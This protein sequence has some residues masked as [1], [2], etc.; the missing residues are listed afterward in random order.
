MSATDPQQKL[1]FN[2]IDA[3]SGEYMFEPLSAAELAASITGAAPP[4]LDLESTKQHL[5]DLEFRHRQGSEAHF[6]VKAGIDATR[7]EE[8]GWAVIFPAASEGS[9]AAREQAAI[10]EALAPLLGLRKSQATAG[11][12]DYYKEYLGEL[13]YR[14][15]ETKQQFL[16]RLGTGPGPADPEK[17]PYYLLIVGSP[18]QIPYH[19][20]YQLD[21]QYAVGRIYFDTIDEY[22]NYA[23]SVV[24]AESGPSLRAR[25]LAFVGVANPD[26]T[27]TTLSRKHLIAP[28]VERVTGSELGKDWTIDCYLDERADKAN[29]AR[30]FGGPQTP[31]LIFSASHGMAFKKGDPLQERHQGALL[32]QDWP[33]PKAWRKAIDE[34]F[35]FCGDDLRSDA[36]LGGLI[37]FNFACYGGGTP[38]YDELGKP[39]SRQRKPIADKPFVAQLHR[40]LLSH[41]RGG[42]LASIGHV[43]RAWGY[44]FLWGTG[45][46]GAAEPQLTVFESTLEALMSGMPVGLALEYFNA[47]Y[48]ELASD[49]SMQLEQLEWDPGAVD[50]ATLSAMWTASNDARGFAI[51]GDPAVRLRFADSQR[52]EDARPSVDL[53]SSAESPRMRESIPNDEQPSSDGSANPSASP[54]LVARL[55]AR[56]AETIE[57]VSTLEVRTYAAD[58]VAAAIEA[59]CDRDA[60]LCAYSRIELDGTAELIVARRDGVIDSELLAQHL[61]LVE[62]TREARI[63]TIEALLAA[64]VELRKLP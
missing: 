22:D 56:L 39:A 59:S 14:S 37:A 9:T 55:L 63:A 21:V 47:R 60:Q 6:G 26:D 10:R 13:G 51:L 34:G 18:E 54:E 57:G 38:R 24:A 23:R 17:V 53:G 33:G 28:L 41:P 11:G 44:S 19:V 20:Q 27:A 64:L 42:A 45:E 32:L 4:Q 8:A 52:C 7:L 2:G 50:A 58:D 1:T 3:R 15:G 5:A 25:E 43:E 30:L 40:K 61:A 49:L 29:V 35:Y 16:A 31:A 12:G 46:G 62:Q 36:G 48:A